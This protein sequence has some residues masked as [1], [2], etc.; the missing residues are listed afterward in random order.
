MSKKWPPKDPREV[1]AVQFDFSAELDTIGTASVVAE[2]ISGDD[3]N[4]SGLLR[5][6][7]QTV[8]TT[9]R[10]RVQSGVDGCHYRLTAVA[11]DGTETYVLVA[12][13]PV[14]IAK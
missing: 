2:T 5:G 8:G 9:V 1:F 12:V 7:A 6:P 11:S 4:P 13:L 14:K 10:Q 3:P